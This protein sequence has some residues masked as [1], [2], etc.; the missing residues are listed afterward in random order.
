MEG[1]RIEKNG[2]RFFRRAKLTLGCS[3][4]GKK[5]SWTFWLSAREMAGYGPEGQCSAVMF[6]STT[7]QT[8]STIL[9]FCPRRQSGQSVTL[10]NMLISSQGKTEHSHI[11]SGTFAFILQCLYSPL[12]DPACFSNFVILFTVGRTT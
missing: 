2:G 3:A 4:K 12:L 11:Y 10:T 8:P 9:H 7:M 5:G 6:T 1:R